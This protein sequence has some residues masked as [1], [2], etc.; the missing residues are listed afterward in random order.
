MPQAV[1]AESKLATNPITQSGAVT[2]GAGALTLRSSVKDNVEQVSGSL[3]LVR[4]V[5]GTASGLVATLRSAL[6]MTSQRCLARQ[7][8]PPGLS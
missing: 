6:G 4:T 5:A 2:A 7:S 3:T 1:A 8:W